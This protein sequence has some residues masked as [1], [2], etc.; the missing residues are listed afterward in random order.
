[1]TSTAFS[2]SDDRRQRVSIRRSAAKS[3]TVTSSAADVALQQ[4]LDR[5]LRKREGRPPAPVARTFGSAQSGVTASID[6]FGLPQWL[7]RVA[8]LGFVT[9]VLGFAVVAAMPAKGGTRGVAVEG[10]VLFKG[11]PL[12]QAALEFHGEG[13]NGPVRVAVDTNETGAFRRPLS[14]GIPSGSYAVIVKSG[15]VMP[16]PQAERGTPVRIP[17][18]YTSVQ[19]TPLKVDV[20][21]EQASFELVLR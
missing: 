4:V 16:N 2:H 3:A 15:C 11:R 1:M 10:R 19:S 6:R 17:A 20:T 18:K 14:A 8:V 13:A 9:F 21:G 5:R 7:F 12:A